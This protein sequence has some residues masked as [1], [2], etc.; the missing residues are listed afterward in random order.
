MAH[1]CALRSSDRRAC[2]AADRCWDGHGP[3]PFGLDIDELERG[4]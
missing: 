2:G 3:V 1:L 4:Q